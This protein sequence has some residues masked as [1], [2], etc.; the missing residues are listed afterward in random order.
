MAKSNG[1]LIPV[2]EIENKTAFPQRRILA[3]I[4]YA[5]KP[6]EPDWDGSP[7][8]SAETARWVV[9]TMEAKDARLRREDQ[10][11]GEQLLRELERDV[12]AK[13]KKAARE[14]ASRVVPG[15]RATFEDETVNFDWDT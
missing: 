2:A 14:N 3:N 9:D 4:E 11:R 15:T 8:V 7:M 13:R 1:R 6:V 10:E 5:R 12:A